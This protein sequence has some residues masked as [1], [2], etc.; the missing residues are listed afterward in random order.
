MKPVLKIFYYVKTLFFFY[1]DPD[2]DIIIQ[3]KQVFLLSIYLDDFY[4][5]IIH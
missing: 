2:A 1:K 5:K 3:Y 4:Q